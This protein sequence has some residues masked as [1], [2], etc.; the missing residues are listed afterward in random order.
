M[1]LFTAAVISTF[2]AYALAWLRIDGSGLIC[3]LAAVLF[4]GSAARI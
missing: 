1:K 3:M 2:A 4:L